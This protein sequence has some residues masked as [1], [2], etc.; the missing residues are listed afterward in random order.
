VQTSYFVRVP[1]AS[2]DSGVKG[3]SSFDE[4]KQHIP[5]RMHFGD[6]SSDGYPDIMLTLSYTNGTSETQILLNV[7]CD[8]SCSAKALKAKRRL[9]ISTKAGI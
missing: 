7:P 9:F 8:K 6:I 5:G 2:G 4:S 1:I 3:L